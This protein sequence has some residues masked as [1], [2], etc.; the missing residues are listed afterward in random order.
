MGTKFSIPNLKDNK[1]ISKKEE[2]IPKCYWCGSIEKDVFRV[3]LFYCRKCYN[4]EM[5]DMREIE[6]NSP[7]YPE[8]NEITDKLYLGNSDG[9]KDKQILKQLGVTHILICGYFLHDF[10]PDE[11]TYKTIELDDSSDENISKYFKE[12]IEYIDQSEKSYIHCRAGVSRSSSI[13]IA[14]I[15]WKNKINFEEALLFV[16]SKRKCISPNP[17]FEMQLKKF[18]QILKQN[19]FI[20]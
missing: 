8:I 13:V 11:F 4:K 9:G 17:G 16:K 15:M 5:G 1:N 2:P 20:I 14:Y 18:E 6:K 3:G 10:H 7:G 19:D 12:S